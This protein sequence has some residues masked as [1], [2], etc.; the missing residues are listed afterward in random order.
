M[1]VS[2]DRL[3]RFRPL[4]VVAAMVMVHCASKELTPDGM[5]DRLI[6]FS[7]AYALVAWAM[8]PAKE[9]R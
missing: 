5:L 1:K 6:Q 9:T 4:A 2:L 3:F 7:L 8:R